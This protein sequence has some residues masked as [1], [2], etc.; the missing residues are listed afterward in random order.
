MSSVLFVC[1][2]NICRSPMAAEVFRGLT[3]AQVE[4]ER[5]S[6]ASAGIR[7]CHAGKPAA[8]LACA[9]AASR[10]YD[11]SRHCARQIVD[12]DLVRFDLI[13]GMGAWHVQQLRSL[14]S[15]SRWPVFHS[16]MDHAPGLDL[17]EVPDPYGAEADAFEHC[18]DLIEVGCRGLFAALF[19]ESGRSE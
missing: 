14:V 10:G 1:T 11:L 13:V 8:A 12:E 5:F 6:V 4:T 15:P 19:R 7:S 3:A 16:L 18:L 17:D 9:A 2:G